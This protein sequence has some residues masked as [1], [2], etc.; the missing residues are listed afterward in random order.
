[1]FFP[2]QVIDINDVSP[3][4]ALEWCNLLPEVTFRLL[5]CGG[6]GTIGWV[7]SA[8]EKLK[9]KVCDYIST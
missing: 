8:I 6:D 3:E 1:M 9:L 5:V 7:L 4:N 2:L